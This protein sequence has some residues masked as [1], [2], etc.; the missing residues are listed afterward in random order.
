[1][2]GFCHARYGSI[3]GGKCD[4]LPVWDQISVLN[5]VAWR[6]RQSVP[7]VRVLLGI[8]RNTM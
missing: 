5:T 4:A 6:L 1:M 3:L 7:G 8:R 2:F